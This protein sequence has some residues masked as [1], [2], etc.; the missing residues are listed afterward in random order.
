MAW[1]FQLS[2]WTPLVVPPLGTILSSQNCKPLKSLPFPILHFA[3]SE[4]VCQNVCQILLL[5]VAL[6]PVKRPLFDPQVLEFLF[7]PLH[8]GKILFST[9]DHD[10]RQHLE[11]TEDPVFWRSRLP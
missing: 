6:Q 1:I 8:N 3:V 7:K 4:N 2:L 9:I 11:G 10:T 5:K